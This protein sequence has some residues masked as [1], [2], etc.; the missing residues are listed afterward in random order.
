MKYGADAAEKHTVSAKMI[1][2]PSLRIHSLTIG[3]EGA[4]LKD[5]KK[6]NCLAQLLADA[7]KG[8]GRAVS[9]SLIN[10]PVC[11]DWKWTGV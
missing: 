5:D 11:V 8:A 4:G 6:L 9:S 3:G 2:K 1:N 7:A 10:H